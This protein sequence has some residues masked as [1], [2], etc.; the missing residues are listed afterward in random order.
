MH[1]SHTPANEPYSAPAL[2]S[3]PNISRSY[4]AMT[5]T[6]P[7]LESRLAALESDLAEHKQVNADLRQRVAEL[8]AASS[9]TGMRKRRCDMVGDL[10]H[11]ERVAERLG[12]TYENAAQRTFHL[13][14]IA[15]ILDHSR[16]I[17]QLNALSLKIRDAVPSFA[18]EETS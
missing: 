2:E 1:F 18:E 10:K 17:E 7:N 16:M 5:N 4:K 13:S 9:C 8:E 12:R 11:A 3:L 15:D 6:L 14:S